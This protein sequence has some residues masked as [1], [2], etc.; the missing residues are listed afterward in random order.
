MTNFSVFMALGGSE[1]PHVK[2]SQPAHVT[3]R[4]IYRS[5]QALGRVFRLINVDEQVL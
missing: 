4:Q 1:F 2:G 3:A 5:A